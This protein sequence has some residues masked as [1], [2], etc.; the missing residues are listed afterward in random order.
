MPD[1]QSEDAVVKDRYIID[2]PKLE[3]G[4]LIHQLIEACP[5]L[6]LN[7]SYA[8]LLQASH[9][10]ATCRVARLQEDPKQI[11][12][13]ISGYCLPD[14]QDTL[15]IWQVAVSSE[16]RGQGLAR[17]ILQS[18]LLPQGRPAYRYLQTTVNPDNTASIALFRR[19]ARDAG[20]VLQRQDFYSSSLFGTSGHEAEDL[21]SIG[22]LYP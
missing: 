13:Y 2:K 8:Y 7:S 16:H 5:P 11:A 9:F 3:D 12:A 19:L 17:H 6:D 22:P 20:S 4:F 1:F 10:S 14:Q 15:F 21:Y 18:L